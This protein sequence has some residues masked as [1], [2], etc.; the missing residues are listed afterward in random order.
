MELLLPFR[1]DTDGRARK[2][3]VEQVA[4]TWGVRRKKRSGWKHPLDLNRNRRRCEKR[5]RSASARVRH[6]LQAIREFEA[7]SEVVEWQLH[8]GSLVRAELSAQRA[9]ERRPSRR[10]EPARAWA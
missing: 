2:G 9:P 10:I 3:V 6:A 8:Q 7:H 4:R 1:L 5:R